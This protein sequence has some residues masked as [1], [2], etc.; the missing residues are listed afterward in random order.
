MK[1][2]SVR[3]WHIWPLS[4]AL[5][6]TATIA[7]GVHIQ[8]QSSAALAIIT[9]AAV[10][11]AHPGQLLT[12]NVAVLSGNYP[13]GVGLIGKDP[14]AFAGP[15]AVSGKSVALALAIPSSLPLGSYSITAAG[16][17]SNGAF[18][19][20]KPV[21][22]DVEWADAPTSL[23]VDPNSVSSWKAGDSLPLTV[24]GVFSDGKKFDVTRSTKLKINSENT[25]V[26][27]VQ[28]GVLAAVGAGQTVIDLQFESVSAK[29]IVTV[30]SANQIGGN[31]PEKTASRISR[32]TAARGE[33]T[34]HGHC[35]SARLHTRRNASCRCARY[36]RPGEL[37]V[38]DPQA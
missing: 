19:L 22:V 6:L 10:L 7:G 14:I 26:A 33:I 31:R 13:N 20:S 29:I 4:L 24:V 3:T 8:A 17:D 11:A 23:I 28:S 36:S 5:V 30:P 16:T 18:Q 35:G 32:I 34:C 12:L 37:E 25:A 15:V 2:G 9:P 21:F 38:L 1:F 27:S